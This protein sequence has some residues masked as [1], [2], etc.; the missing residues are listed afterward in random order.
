MTPMREHDGALNVEIQRTVVLQAA[1]LPS[2]TDDVEVAL[3]KFRRFS[4]LS[5]IL[6]RH[7]RE[8]KQVLVPAP[9]RSRTVPVKT[10][11]SIALSIVI[12]TVVSTITF[13]I[14]GLILYGSIIDSHSNV[15]VAAALVRRATEPSEK[16]MAAASVNGVALPAGAGVP[17]EGSERNGICEPTLLFPSATCPSFDMANMS[18]VDFLEAQHMPFAFDDR[19]ALASTHSINNYRGT[20]EQ[21]RHLLKILQQEF[22]ERCNSAAT[23]VVY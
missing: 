23:G 11:A 17:C 16:I 18:V 21:N 13:S 5:A 10:Y 15:H 3:Q 12:I 9:V 2:R 4:T 7:N 19:V 20:A 14:A 22:A 8:Q 1:P 6:S